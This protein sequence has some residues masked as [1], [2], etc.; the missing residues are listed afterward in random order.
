MSNGSAHRLKERTPKSD[1]KGFNLL[2]HA[3]IS[4]FVS[5]IFNE[6]LVSV[7]VIATKV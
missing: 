5:Y 6:S 1:W 3:V 2:V 7:E 4:E